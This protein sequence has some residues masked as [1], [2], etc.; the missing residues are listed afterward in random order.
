MTFFLCCLAFV[1][2]SVNLFNDNR[3]LTLHLNYHGIGEMYMPQQ[4]L[5]KNV[6]KYD[7]KA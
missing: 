7:V 5:G 1:P 6:E 2:L 3:W 4:N